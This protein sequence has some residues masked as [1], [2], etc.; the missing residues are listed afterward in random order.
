MIVE[1]TL[2]IDYDSGDVG[3]IKRHL[4]AAAEHLYDNGLLSGNDPDITI[5]GCTCSVALLH[6]DSLSVPYKWEGIPYKWEGTPYK[7]E[8]TPYKWEGIPYKWEGTLYKW[9]GAPK[10]KGAQ[11]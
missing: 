3:E 2:F 11:K 8:G 1:L 5:S 7:W 9:E 10:P 4:C 6:R